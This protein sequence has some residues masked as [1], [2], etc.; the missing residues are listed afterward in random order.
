MCLKKRTI[1]DNKKSNFREMKKNINDFPIL[2]ILYLLGAGGFGLAILKFLIY[3]FK[4]SPNVLLMDLLSL[5]FFLA[6]LFFADKSIRSMRSHQQ[7]VDEECNALRKRSQIEK[8][9]LQEKVAIYEEKE[10]EALR[11]ASYQEKIMQQIFENKSVLKDKHRFLHLLSELFQA[12]AVILYKETKPKGNFD[13]EAIYAIPEDFQP[14]SFVEGEGLNGQAVADGVP[15]VIE[16]IPEHFLPI[17]SG[18]GSSSSVY[19][20]LLP[21]MKEG[22]CT[23]LIEMATFVKSDIARLWEELSKKLVEKEVL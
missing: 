12:G 15:M 11:F 3:S 21:V 8:E 5:L 4:L 7:T 9:A 17:S 6:L 19:L 2:T 14:R 18:L 10:N 23:H 16:D 22:R 1:L 13:V 20:Y